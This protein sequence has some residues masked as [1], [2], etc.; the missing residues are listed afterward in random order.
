MADGTAPTAVVV[1]VSDG[2]AHGA[3]EDTSGEALATMLREHG[4]RL[5]PR[6]VVP[7]E[8]ERI[9]DTLRTA[10]VDGVALVVTTG[11]TGFGPRDVTPEATVAVATRRAPGLA[12]RMRA[13]GREVTPMA[14]LSRGE[15]VMVGRMLVLNT[16]GSRKGAVESLGAVIDLLPHAV[17]LLAGD[18]RRHPTGHGTEGEPGEPV[19]VT[20]GGTADAPH[21]HIGHDDHGGH[22]HHDDAHAA[23]AGDAADDPHAHGGH[24]DHGGH[25]EGDPCALAHAA[26]V[27]DERRPGTL[28]AVYSSPLS[29]LLLSWGRDLGY[30][31]LV[32]VEP[33]GEA[34]H[35]GRHADEVVAAVADAGV[36]DDTDVV[37]TDHHRRDIVAV[38]D[39]MLASPA[40]YLGLMGSARHTG[41][42][43]DGLRERG[44]SDDEIARIERPI[45]L[46]IG[47]KTPPEIALSV[48]AGLVADRQGRR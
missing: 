43:V 41:P 31:R 4:W 30:R 11:G 22:G 9:T 24:D 25:D 38:A 20:D 32:L 15:A 34:G 3:R 33:T 47:S 14:D 40:R 46:D 21:A 1:T 35:A 17:Q 36:D 27:P 12:E 2:A 8:V 39:E 44:R 19:A 23:T 16:P 29:S 18:T 10:A 5:G 7:D 28:V 13:V 37:V 45:G 48:L 6:V 26:G 42:H